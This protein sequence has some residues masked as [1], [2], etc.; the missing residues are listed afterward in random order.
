M[1]KINSLAAAVL[2]AVMASP[3]AFADDGWT[4]NVD[5]HG[6]FRAGVGQSRSGANIGGLN[7]GHVG[8]LGNEGDTYSEV[9]LG[10][11]VWKQGDLSFYVDAMFA[12]FSDGGQDVEVVRHNGSND[13]YEVDEDFSNGNRTGFAFRQF[14]LQVK[15]LIPGDKDAVLWAGKR[16]YQRHDIHIID[17]KYVNVSGSGAGLE[18]WHVGPGQLSLAWFR[19]DREDQFTT[20]NYAQEATN[21]SKK[22]FTNVNIYDIRYAGSYWDGGWL[23]FISSTFVPNKGQTAGSTN[24]RYYSNYDNKTSEQFTVDIVQGGSWGYNKT[25]LQYGSANMAQA[26]WQGSGSWY[27]ANGDFSDANGYSIY[28]TGA[29]R[30][31]ES[32]F[33]MEHV[34]NFAYFNNNK[35]VWGYKQGKSFKA[36]VRPCWLL[37]DRSHSGQ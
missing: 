34:V 14:N 26:V 11:T 27:A 12:M 15:G 22:W 16:F 28:N 3:A 5:F 33:R 13:A 2:A 7:V 18:N 23:E 4:P 31:G 32:N 17:Q 9:E 36:V 1:K 6:Y 37:Q 24:D 25:V 8:R 21:E 35:D 20:Y 30:F 10:S 29:T 19:S